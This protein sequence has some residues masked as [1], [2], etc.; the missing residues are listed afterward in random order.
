MKRHKGTWVV[1]LVVLASL[2]ICGVCGLAAVWSAQGGPKVPLRAQG[3]AVI[4]VMGTILAGGGEWPLPTQSIVYSDRVVQDIQHAE[5]DP[6]VAAIVLEINSPGG[7]VVGSVDIYQAVR[8]AQKPVVASI[9]EMGASGGYY[10][11][12]GADRIVVRPASI[13]GSIGVIMEML[14]ASQLAS[15]LGVTLEVIKTGPYKDQGSWHRPLTAEERALLQ[16]MLDEAYEDFIRVIVEGRELNEEQVRAIAD[17]RIL[18]GRQAV[19]LGLAD[20]EG[21]LQDAISLAGELAGLS[22]PQEIRYERKPG[23]FEF[24][25]GALW[26]GRETDLTILRDLLASGRSPAMQYLYVAP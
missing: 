20:R 10:I 5:D 15:K 7:S 22:A 1:A 11:A 9:G 21:S 19:R 23:L 18:S 26:Q 16:G 14:N 6:A 2:S 24:L 8:A 4:P 17:G 3:V 12:C 13:T 25:L